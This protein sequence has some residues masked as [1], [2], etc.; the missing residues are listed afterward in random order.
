MDEDES[1]SKSI[2]G[3]RY[4]EIG[5]E[6][7]GAVAGFCL[8]GWWIDRHWQIEDHRALLVCAI[9]GLI[10]G[11]YNMIRQALTVS[12]EIAEVDRRRAEGTEAGGP[13]SR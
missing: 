13:D 5:L 9:L 10:G 11:M 8:V 12:R 7:A 2:A 6:F 3:T 1:P 4:A